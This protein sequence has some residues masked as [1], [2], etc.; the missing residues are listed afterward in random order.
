MSIARRVGMVVGAALLVSMS[1]AALALDKNVGSGFLSDYGLLAD[2]PD[3]PES[4]IWVSPKAASG[5]YT[6]VIVDPVVTHLSSVLIEEG[7]K[8]DPKLLNETVA[9]LQDAVAREFA[10]AGWSVVDQPGENTLRYRAAIT[11]IKA[12]GGG[13]STNP[14]NYLPAVFVV[15]T[16]TGAGT[17]ESATAHIFM[18]SSYS[19][20]L[21]GEV[22]GEVL[23]GATGDSVQG[24]DI[25]LGNVKGVL[26]EWAKKAGEASAEAILQ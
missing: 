14:V 6:S 11:G 24:D 1:G 15:R 21:T 7:A 25:S 13:A 5:S 16:V 8:P 4:M 9:Y 12:E 3:Y 26:D 23:Q 18:E 10:A 17:T 19:D 2:D 20:S 22:V